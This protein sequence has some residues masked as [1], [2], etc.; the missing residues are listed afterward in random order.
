MQRF[1]VFILIPISCDAIRGAVR[2]SGE[3]FARNTVTAITSERRSERQ[4]KQFG[5]FSE[6]QIKTERLENSNLI[7]FVQVHRRCDVSVKQ[8][9]YS[10]SLTIAGI[11]FDQNSVAL[12]LKCF[13]T[14]FADTLN[15]ISKYCWLVPSYAGHVTFRYFLKSIG[16]FGLLKTKTKYV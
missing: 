5:W 9:S 6:W 2:N 1:E 11:S 7:P 12:A 3:K 4:N 10:V 16:V 13:F 8:A 15:D 14:D